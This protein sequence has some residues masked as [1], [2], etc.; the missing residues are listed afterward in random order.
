[1]SQFCKNSF[2]PFCEL[3]ILIFLTMSEISA[4]KSSLFCC[5]HEHGLICSAFHFK[6]EYY[7]AHKDEYRFHNNH[8]TTALEDCTGELADARDGDGPFYADFRET[9]DKMILTPRETVD[10]EYN[11]NED[12]GIWSDFTPSIPSESSHSNLIQVAKDIVTHLNL[13]VWLVEFSGS[14]KG[15]IGYT[16]WRFQP[17][18][19]RLVPP[20]DPQPMTREPEFVYCDSMTDSQKARITNLDYGTKVLFVFRPSLL[21]LKNILDIEKRVGSPMCPLLKKNLIQ[22]K[23]FAE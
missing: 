16:N 15:Y 7:E 21:Y 6:V 14:C 5:G 13:P 20:F 22:L 9:R 17:S 19:G 18:R 12:G 3:C 11:Y 4:V 2:L 1:M 8:R 10:P 23:F